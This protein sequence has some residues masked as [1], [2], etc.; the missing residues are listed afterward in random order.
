[1]EAGGAIAVNLDDFYAYMTRRMIDA[2][3]ATMR[4]R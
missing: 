2:S 4:M 3:V 1:M